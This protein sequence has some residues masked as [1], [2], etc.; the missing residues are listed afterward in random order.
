MIDFLYNKMV[1]EKRSEYD[2]ELEIYLTEKTEV[3]EENNLGLDYNVLFWWKQDNGKFHVLS[4][5]AK[6]VLTV[7]ISYVAF[8]SM[9]NTSE[10]ILDLYISSLIFYMIKAAHN[11]EYGFQINLNHQLPT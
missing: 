8:E 7:Q 9:L 2:I 4:E 3:R 6:D 10:R 1:S 11:N 5:L